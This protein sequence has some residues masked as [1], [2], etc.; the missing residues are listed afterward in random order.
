[1]EQRGDGR[2]RVAMSG[3]VKVGRAVPEHLDRRLLAEELRTI[4]LQ[5]LRPA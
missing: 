4:V 5:D 2:G 1:M 3:R